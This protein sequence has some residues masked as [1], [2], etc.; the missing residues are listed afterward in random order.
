MAHGI[1]HCPGC[2][3]YS[4]D[5][6]GPCGGIRLE[7]IMGSFA[8]CNFDGR[9]LDPRD[10]QALADF[11]VTL[12]AYAG[13]NALRW[14]ERAGDPDS[15]YFW[16][17][18]YCEP[19]APGT[20]YFVMKQEWAALDEKTPV[21]RI[22]EVRMADAVAQ[23]QVAAAGADRD[24]PARPGP[25]AAAGAGLPGRQAVPAEERPRGAGGRGQAQDA[26]R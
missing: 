20:R 7:E 5:W 18:W 4:R 24:G 25:A 9:P 15:G 3:G 8:R 6:K 26:P 17:D 13:D 14:R 2:N 12:A 21:R 19:P 23:E 16:Q 22:F 10:A 1:E 11:G